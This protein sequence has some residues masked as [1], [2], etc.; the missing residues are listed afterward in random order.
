M[1]K[2]TK[3]LIQRIGII[4]LVAV[5]FAS[6]KKDDLPLPK[7]KEV[8]FIIKNVPEAPATLTGLSVI[9]SLKNTAGQE[10]VTNRKLAVTYNGKYI[11]EKLQLSEGNYKVSKFLVTGTSAKV[12][13][14]APYNRISQSIPG[15]K[16]PCNRFVV[17]PA[18]CFATTR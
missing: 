18:F 8:Q 5:A 12:Q 10:V 2:M 4:A 17:A 13:F 3:K 16:A 6:C 15:A 7:N 11:S 9:V 1:K 14:A